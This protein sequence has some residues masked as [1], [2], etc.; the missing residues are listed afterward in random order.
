ME[1]AAPVHV[2]HDILSDAEMPGL[3]AAATHYISLS[4][5]EGWDL[6]M[7]EAGGSGL[8]LIAPRHSAYQ[9]YLD[10]S[11][12]TLLPSREVPIVWTGDAASG[13][14]FRGANWWEPDEDAAV[15]A[16]R[17]AIGGR[18]ETKASAR[19]RIL[20]EFTWQRATESLLEI[21]SLKNSDVKKERQWFPW[22][23]RRNKGV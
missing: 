2:L 13:E 21:L 19:E 14:L 16:I 23:P 18:D 17:A 12:A 7:M 4:H 15:A 10:D 22:W 5:G 20:T 11:V 6:P 8:K 3:Y 1:M 9:A